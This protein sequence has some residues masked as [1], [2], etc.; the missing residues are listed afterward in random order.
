[1]IILCTNLLVNY[2]LTPLEDTPPP[3]VLQESPL[4]STH[5]IQYNSSLHARQVVLSLAELQI[6]QVYIT[7]CK[8]S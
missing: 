1:M 6:Y 2:H 8:N 4:S 5:C 3:P 7:D